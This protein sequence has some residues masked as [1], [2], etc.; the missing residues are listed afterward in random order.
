MQLKNKRRYSSLKAWRLGQRLS[1]VEAA[2]ILNVSQ[3]EYSRYEAGQRPPKPHRAK[4]IAD[5]TGVSLAS[6]L[7][8][9]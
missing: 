1:Q 8:V 5:V 9:A 6:V 4:A 2:E 7:G 3:G